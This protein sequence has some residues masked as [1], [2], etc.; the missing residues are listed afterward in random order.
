MKTRG[1]EFDNL[2]VKTYME[3]HSAYKTGQRLGV[4]HKYVYRILHER[5]VSIPGWSDEKPHRRAIPADVEPKVIE[6]HANGVTFKSMCAK[7]G[8]SDWAVR[9]LIKRS[10]SKRRAHGGQVRQFSK[11][12]IEEMKRLSSEGWSQTAIAASLGTTQISVSRRLISAGISSKKN[13]SGENHGSWK[14]GVT[15]TQHGYLQ[16]LAPAD[17]PMASMRTVTGYIL[18]HRLV[19]A[20]SIGRPLG[21]R[22]TV[23]HING[24]VTDNRIENLQLRQGL[25]GNGVVMKCACCGSTNI[26][27]TKI[28]EAD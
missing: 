12:D 15:V 3:N 26:I 20:E 18:Q 23:H 21:R 28:A 9:Y 14:G 25:H 4:S 24:V 5:G 13:A 10:G 7:Y 16:V 2:L 22:E 8:C 17:H 11:N 6:D 19:M 27:S 1:E